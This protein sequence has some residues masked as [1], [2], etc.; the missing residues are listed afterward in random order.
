MRAGNLDRRITIQSKSVTQSDSGEEA[1]TWSD[2]ATVWAE[3]IENR[4]N[5]RFVAHQFLG[6]PV[7]TFRFRWSRSVAQELTD[8]H[9]IIFD[10][11]AFDITDI[12]EI[13]RRVGIEIDCYAK[14]EETLIAAPVT[15]LIFSNANNAAYIALLE[16]I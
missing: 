6:H 14:G 1:A 15:G 12:R 13:G 10:D 9:R 8:K 4:G 5:E 2:F 7:K 16:D 3:K 11:R